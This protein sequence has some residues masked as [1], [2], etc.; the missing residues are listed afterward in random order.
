MT[1]KNDLDS[2]YFHFS[3]KEKCIV[4]EQWRRIKL[5]PSEKPL[6]IRA[7]YFIGQIFLAMHARHI[8]NDLFLV[9]MLSDINGSS[10][11]F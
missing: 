6:E 9:K 7:T 10:W 3:S 11:Y 5:I 1:K 8:I 4:H 2:F